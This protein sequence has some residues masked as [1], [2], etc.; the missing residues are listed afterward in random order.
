MRFSVVV[1]TLG[2]NS[3]KLSKCLQSLNNQTISDLEIVVVTRCDISQ[4]LRRLATKVI[5]E[6]KRGVSLA[7]NRGISSCSGDVIGFTDEDCVC[8]KNW[9]EKLAVQFCDPSVWLVTGKT[10]PSG[11]LLPASI[12]INPQRT[13]FR[14][15]GR[16]ISYHRIGNGNNMAI[17]RIAFKKIG[18]FDENFGPGTRNMSAEDSDIILRILL[19]GGTVVYEPSAIVY[20]ETFVYQDWVWR[21]YFSYRVGEGALY[22]K[23]GSA[24]LSPNTHMVYVNRLKEMSFHFAK[25][26]IRLQIKEASLT[27]LSFCSLSLGFIQCK[28]ILYQEMKHEDLP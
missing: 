21:Q 14:L 12:A 9:A 24:R 7:K 18:M 8:S 23:F 20:H 26:M 6:P 2:V 11:N 3:S 13:I 22:K 15:D 28:G 25:C 16:Y 10:I 1:C 19:Q 4:E 5:V 27:V 17:R